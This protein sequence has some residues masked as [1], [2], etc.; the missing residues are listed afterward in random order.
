MTL[1]QLESFLMVARELNFRRA[2]ELLHLSQPAVS[3]QIHHL[4]A[5]L[6]QPL[7]ERS[8][9]QVSLTQA[10]ELLLQYAEQ[11]LSLT[12]E[13]QQAVSDLHS[14]PRGRVI[15]GTTIAIV[16][17]V[18]PAVLRQMQRRYPEIAVRIHTYTTEGTINSLLAGEIDLGL[19]YTTHMVPGLLTEPFFDDHFI[20]ICSPN[21]P[22]AQRERVS[23]AEIN[24]QPMIFLTKETAL[25]PT[26]DRRLAELNLR[27]EPIMELPTSEAVKKMVELDLGIAVV[28]RLAVAAELAAGKLVTVPL[29]E[30]HLVE[31]TV[32][33]YRENKYLNLAMRKLIEV[34]REVVTGS[35]SS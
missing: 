10:G 4:E 12:T 18:F 31:R 22:F 16:V 6:R 11:I 9:R 24:G 34:C 2:A 1:A 35:A 21:H 32:F 15:L 17:E 26:L 33:L 5:E 25:G 20:P 13:A 3:A 7:F 27:P 29:P 30:L 28:S 8:A 23:P 14:E 19:A